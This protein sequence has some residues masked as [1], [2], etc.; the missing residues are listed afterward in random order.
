MR[1][2]LTL[3]PLT[4][5][6]AIR[7]QIGQC[8]EKPMGLRFFAQGPL[9]GP[10]M[11]LTKQEKAWFFLLCGDQPKINKLI[12]LVFYLSNSIRSVQE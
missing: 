12:F 5:P 7:R 6:E 10:F 8:S 4:L 9:S 1:V 2:K 3:T 11:L